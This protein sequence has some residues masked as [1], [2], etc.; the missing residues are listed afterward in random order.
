MV[1]H[2]L[3]DARRLDLFV[4]AR[5]TNAPCQSDTLMLPAA[6]RAALETLL[7]GVSRRDLAQRSTRISDH[8]RQGRA[9]AAAIR[10][11]L[12]A[13]AYAIARMPATLAA[14]AIAAKRA[15]SHLPAQFAPRSL[16]DLGAGA[17]AATL[18]LRAQWPTLE[19]VTMI[20]NHPAFRKLAQR[21][22]GSRSLDRTDASPDPGWLDLRPGDLADANWHASPA[23]V[24]IASYVLVELPTAA[25]QRL[26][27]KA[28]GL[29]GLLVL[30][31]PGTPE[32][33][34]RLSL[35]RSALINAGAALVAPCPGPVECPMSD[36]DWCH[37]AARVQRS[38]DHKYL[39]GAD[40][41]FEDERFAFLVATP[42]QP[43]TPTTARILAKP[44]IERSGVTLK[45]C[46]PAGL[47]TRQVLSRD[48]AAFKRA[49]KLAWGDTC[50]E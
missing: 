26:A 2:A 38:R 29:A 8:Y 37:F 18:A 41:P 45:L 49:R 42:A 27:V 11:D 15:A 9:S 50:D 25:V 21:L 16:L 39:K 6:Q 31:E 46:T 43:A 36:G 22:C 47:E 12:D 1:E 23:D 3:A 19:H 10:D 30:V 24:V 40:A 34:A 7:D 17:G 4:Q 32:G 20:E 13:L 48:K 28:L 14:C 33:F 5:R 44:I 35:A